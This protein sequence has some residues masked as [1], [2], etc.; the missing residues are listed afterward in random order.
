MSYGTP[1]KDPHSSTGYYIPEN[2]T[3]AIVEV[4]RIMGTRG[5]HETLS[6]SESDMCM[7][8]HTFGSWL[9]NNWGLWGDT[10]LVEYFNRLGIT[11]ADDMSGIILVSYWRTLH[12]VPLEI[13][14]QIK[15]YQDYWKL[16]MSSD[17]PITIE[18]S[19]GIT[20]ITG[21]PTT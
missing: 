15:M 7:Y 5:R 17:L 18:K 11:H 8:H 1:Q 19:E 3:E 2:L 14:A 20:I 13:N 16:V 12:N 4:D 9:R 10:R 6:R 21:G